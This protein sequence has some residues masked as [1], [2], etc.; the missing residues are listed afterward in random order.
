MLAI[1]GVEGDS[2]MSERCSD[3]RDRGGNREDRKERLL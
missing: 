3:G 2:A 1:L